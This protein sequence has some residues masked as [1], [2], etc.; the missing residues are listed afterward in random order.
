MTHLNC[1]H[2]GYDWTYS[3]ELQLATCPSCGG[4][5]DTTEEVE[6]DV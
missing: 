4:K 6:A 3:G 5:V 2:C 1:P